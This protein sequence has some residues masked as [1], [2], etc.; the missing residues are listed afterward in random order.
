MKRDID[1]ELTNICDALRLTLFSHLW[2]FLIRS[3]SASNNVL[4]LKFNF[5][6]CEPAIIFNF[7]LS[8]DRQTFVDK[9]GSY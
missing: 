4:Y 8:I 9:L 6:R 5:W 1:F 7:E 3:Y 2:I